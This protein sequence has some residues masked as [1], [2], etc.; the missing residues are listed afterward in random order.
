MESKFIEWVNH[1]LDECMPLNAAALCFNLYEEGKNKWSVQLIAT[2]SFD[3]EDPDWACFEV[4]SSGE[5]LY[6]WK[7]KG[8]WE[9]IQ[10][11]S[12]EWVRKYLTDGKYAKEM[13]EYA[14]VAVGFVDGDLTIIYKGTSE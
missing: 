10:K 5:D 11:T 6:T 3:E 8:E 13:K 2:E 9:A 1:L 7:Q 4:Y 14:A 12:T